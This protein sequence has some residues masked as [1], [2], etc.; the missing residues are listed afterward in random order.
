M[1]ALELKVGE[2]ERLLQQQ[3]V[4]LSERDTAVR[5]LEHKMQVLKAELDACMQ[6]QPMRSGKTRE[7]CTVS[8]GI[9][10]VS[11]IRLFQQEQL[12]ELM[13]SCGLFGALDG[14]VLLGKNLLYYGHDDNKAQVNPNKCKKTHIK[15]CG[16]R[17][18][19]D[20][21]RKGYKPRQD[22]MCMVCYQHILGRML[23]IFTMKGWFMAKGTYAF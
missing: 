1:R 8:E 21:E 12:E 7:D 18:I 4:A 23:G 6:R 14:G 15:G 2:D 17:H 9:R 13:V 22:E 5:R 16:C 20:N 3:K 19:T 11:E 10:S